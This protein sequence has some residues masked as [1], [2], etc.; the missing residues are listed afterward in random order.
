MLRSHQMIWIFKGDP[1]A[2]AHR[3][4]HNHHLSSE[5][6]VC[7]TDAAKNHISIGMTGKRMN[8]DQ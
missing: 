1:R 8:Y 6:A 3:K 7:R 2:D 4:I 5:K